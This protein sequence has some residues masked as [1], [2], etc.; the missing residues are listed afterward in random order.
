LRYNPG[1]RPVSDTII[2]GDVHGC[3]D[4]LA[5]LLRVCGAGT[6]DEVVLVGD[7]VA[8]GPDSRGVLAL[9]G[10]IGARAVRG[11]HDARVLSWRAAQ[12]Q[13]V[14]EPPLSLTHL[15]VARS[16]DER[17]WAMLDGL[18]L[19]LRLPQHNAL[20]VHAGLMPG[21]PV[22]VQDPELLMNMRSIGPDGSGT[23]V[24]DE[25]VLWGSLWRGP[26][27][28]VFGHHASRGLQ[29]HRL[30]IGLD[31]GCVY[32]GSLTAYVLPEGRFVSVPAR[33]Q[34]VS[35]DRERP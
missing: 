16:L 2:I 26:E 27:L 20:V 31:T 19:F 32:G 21:V 30:A 23:K 4:E 34:Y 12:K 7:L 24:P 6:D 9:V 18:P 22:E 17:E 13:G 25:G 3:A 33:R 15:T 35:I 29:Q 14:P 28:V 8:K 11:N 5:L 1:Y 10:E